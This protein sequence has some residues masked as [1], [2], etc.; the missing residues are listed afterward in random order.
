MN[1]TTTTTH[2]SHAK[3]NSWY[4]RLLA[5]GEENR[6]GMIS[7]ILLIVGCAGGI[8]V[9]LGGIG[10]DFA[11][12]G[13]IASTMFC[14]SMILAVAPMKYII[15]AGIAAAIIDIIVLIT[16]VIPGL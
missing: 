15:G 14:L 7:A 3:G 6:F 16:V 1:T 13:L 4:S 5:Y 8:T 2:Q 11:L 12:I 10:N 9:G